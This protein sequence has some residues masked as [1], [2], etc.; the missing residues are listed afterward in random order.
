MCSLAV[1]GLT[2]VLQCSFGEIPTPLVVLPTRNVTVEFSLMGNITDMIPFV[3]IILFGTCKSPANPLRLVTQGE[4]PPCT[5]AITTPWV[6]GAG[7]VLVQGMPAIDYGS[8]LFCAYGGVI[9]I[10]FPG[11]FTVKV[12]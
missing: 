5:P 12:P 7:N 3:N 6:S 1:G 8:Q 11:V 9:T 2:S 10:L 4:D